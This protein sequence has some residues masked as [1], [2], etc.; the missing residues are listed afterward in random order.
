MLRAM[1][2]PAD[3]THPAA[4]GL[5]AARPSDYF[6][7]TFVAPGMSGLQFRALPPIEPPTEGKWLATFILNNALRTRILPPYRA[8]LVNY[9]RRVEG[10]VAE[11]QAAS[12]SLEACA[13]ASR[14]NVSG[15]FDALRHL[16]QCVGQ[17]DEALALVAK[18][19]GDKQAFTP[20]EQSLERRLRWVHNDVKHIDEHIVKGKVPAPAGIDVHLTS[21]SIRS[22]KSEVTFL[23]L[24]AVLGQLSELAGQAALIHASG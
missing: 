8:L 23:E 18:V 20:G 13:K 6:L 11:Y 9:L 10:A 14:T 21:T 17:A 19:F 2:T 16:E 15:Y 4:L 22:E 12:G 5:S 7:D 3:D 24:A 1:T